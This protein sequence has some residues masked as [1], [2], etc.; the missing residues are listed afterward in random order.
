MTAGW[1]DEWAIGQANDDARTEAYVRELET[2]PVTDIRVGDR[3]RGLG[4]GQEPHEV[5]A[6][7]RSTLRPGADDIT[8]MVAGLEI[9][10]MY[11]PGEFVIEGRTK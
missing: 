7:K 8:F 2:Q 6:V 9:V 11:R 4:V 1:I 10:R 5:V 3:V